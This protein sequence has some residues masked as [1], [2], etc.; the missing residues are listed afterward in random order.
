TSPVTQ[1]HEFYPRQAYPPQGNGSTLGS[2]L[3]PRAIEPVIEPIADFR[4]RQRHDLASLI[5]RSPGAGSVKPQKSER[6]AFCSIGDRNSACGRRVAFGAT[7]AAL[8][9]G[10]IRRDRIF[11]LCFPDPKLG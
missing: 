2:T 5:H 3:P 1:T 6:I 9:Y 11:P 4:G 8:H 10:I 7:G